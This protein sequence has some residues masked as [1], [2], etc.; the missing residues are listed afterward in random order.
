[1]SSLPLRG[2]GTAEAGSGAA[3]GSLAFAA[4]DELGLYLVCDGAETAALAC[5]AIAREVD[6]RP[7]LA[8]GAR[9]ER[10]FAGASDAVGAERR[11]LGGGAVSAV[12]CLRA[13]DAAVVIAHVGACRAYLFRGGRL[14]RLTE[15]HTVVAELVQRGQLA[16]ADAAHHPYAAVL[17]R[18][19]GA[20]DAP[21]V[22]LRELPLRPGD[23]LLLCS[24][25]VSAAASAAGVE[26]LLSGAEDAAHTAAELVELARRGGGAIAAVVVDTGD[27]PAARPSAGHGDDWWRL[28]PRF[29]D[30]ARRRGLA[31][32]P[33]CAVLSEDEAVAI[34][35]GNLCEAIFFDLEQGSGLHVWTYADNLARGWFDQGGRHAEL[36][37]L[38]D[39]LR[40]SAVAVIAGAGAG[41]AAAARL[42]AAVL[43][44]LAVAEV[45]LGELVGQR[46]TELDAGAAEAD[47][48]PIDAPVT[49]PFAPQRPD[50]PSPAVAARLE[51]ARGDALARAEG[52]AAL[53]IEHAHRAALDFAGVAD[54]GAAVRELCASA[55]GLEDAVRSVAEELERGRREHVEAVA[56][57]DAGADAD[58]LHEV[59]AAALRRVALAHQSLAHAF[60]LAVCDAGRPATD[61]LRARSERIAALRDRLAR[62]ERRVAELGH[63][64]RRRG[65]RTPR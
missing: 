2:A 48:A 1:M 9:L 25:A 50:P 37:A 28:R 43:R 24:S 5:R 16:V 19:L 54:F 55:P 17:S 15:D 40:E 47:A 8:A 7:E 39:L 14:L 18:Q 49:V 64:L 22:E 45:A 29:C 42:E 63:E 11:E 41:E 32:S 57:S 36:R 26:Q 59:R 62:G 35:A 20:G 38:L 34:V 12:A 27:G 58:V 13:G 3:A 61:T 56:G 33:L 44:A 10:A 21:P 23:R 4:D 52:R 6:A 53:A 46:L 65:E 31:R 60:A 51:R 30:E